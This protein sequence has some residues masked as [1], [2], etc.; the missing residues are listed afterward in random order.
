MSIKAAASAMIDAGLKDTKEKIIEKVFRLYDIY[1]FED[2][3]IFQKYLMEKQGRVNYKILANGINAYRRVRSSFLEPY[4]NVTSTL[5][6]LK[7]KGM[8]LA[9]VSDA[10]KLK[11]WL[12]LTAM[13]ID[14]F[15]DVVVSFDD[16]RRLKPSR[17]PLY[18]VEIIFKYVSKFSFLSLHIR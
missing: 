15:F 12:R 4:P 10:P 5:I 6:S 2:K 14:H 8:K 7:Q 17:K 16:T 13:K 18:I 11:L 1:G 9:I 3:T